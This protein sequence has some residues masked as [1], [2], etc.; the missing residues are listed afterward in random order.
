M[1]GPLFGT[2]VIAGH[3]ARRQVAGGPVYLARASIAFAIGLALTSCGGE[4]ADP[5]PALGAPLVFQAEAPSGASRSTFDTNMIGREAC[6]YG[7]DGED[8]RDLDRRCV[9]TPE[10]RSAL[11]TRLS[12]DATRVRKDV[13]EALS[14]HSRELG[15]ALER[16]GRVPRLLRDLFTYDPPHVSDRQ[17]DIAGALATTI[18][19]DALR[20]L[21]EQSS[22]IERDAEALA[23]ALFDDELGYFADLLAG[24]ENSRAHA[25]AHMRKAITAFLKIYRK[26]LAPTLDDVEEQP[27]SPYGTRWVRKEIV[28]V[29]TIPGRATYALVEVT[30]EYAAMFSATSLRFLRWIESP[31]GVSFEDV[32]VD[33]QPVDAK[34]IRDLPLLAPGMFANRGRPT[35]W[36]H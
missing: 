31:A 36:T 14:A 8:P 34:H 12:R 6:A 23:A 30:Q 26:Q 19:T 10:E 11:R 28:R 22:T 33:S 2:Q 13:A 21:F 29:D 20:D 32:L 25:I 16:D 15:R 27:L 35:P 5:M 7:P 4:H 1:V 3:T 9:L 24:W 18:G 17:S